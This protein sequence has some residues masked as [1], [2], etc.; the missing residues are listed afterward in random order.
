MR[1]SKLNNDT[2]YYKY[3][4]LYVDACLVVSEHPD[5]ALRRLD[6]YFQLQE[7]SVGLPK[8]YLGGTL[9]KIR[10]LNEAVARAISAS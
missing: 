2:E 6:K 9:S 7:E 5:E 8:L 10:L 3:V 4:I 1:S